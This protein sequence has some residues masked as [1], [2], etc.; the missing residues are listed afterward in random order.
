[1]EV[2]HEKGQ[3]R[4]EVVKDYENAIP[5]VS[6]SHPGQPTKRFVRV[7]PPS[8]QYL[9]IEPSIEA[10]PEMELVSVSVDYKTTLKGLGRQ[11]EASL[12]CSSAFWSKEM[13]CSVRSGRAG[14]YGALAV[15]SASRP[16]HA[17]QW[18]DL[19]SDEWIPA[20][21]TKK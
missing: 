7:Y 21:A 3:E 6:L 12:D 17:R 4:E 10:E 13:S 14:T 8:Y 9:V 5:G 19:E 18:G 1:M 20:E 2:I 15:V 16:V 11:W